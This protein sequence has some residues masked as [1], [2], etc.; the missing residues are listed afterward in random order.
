MSNQDQVISA[1]A[2]LV[3]ATLTALWLMRR[4]K[5]RRASD[6]PTEV[7][8]VESTAVTL[9]SGGGQPGSAAYYAELKYSYAVRGQTYFGGVR[10]RFILK[11]R[12]DK[13]IAGFAKSKVLT[14]RYNPEKA[15]DSVLL[16]SDHVGAGSASGSLDSMGKA[17]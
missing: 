16:E 9:E 2:V 6:W 5:M 4:A 8:H 12:A 10:R 13:W 7:G 15:R 14:V 11:G 1:I 17:R 3:L